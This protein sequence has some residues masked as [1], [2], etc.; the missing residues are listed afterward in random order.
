MSGF[1]RMVPVAAF[2]ALAA[3]SM[4]AAPAS[5]SPATSGQTHKVASKSCHNA[6]GHKIACAKEK[7]APRTVNHAAP[8][9]AMPKTR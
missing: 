2:S 1:K 7:A 8:T 3:L 4:A 6:Q 5:A 9:P